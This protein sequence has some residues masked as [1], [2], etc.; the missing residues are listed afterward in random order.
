MGAELR[1]LLLVDALQRQAA[2][3]VAFYPRSRLQ[4]A[5]EDGEI[6]F[7]FENGEACGYLWHGP[8]NPGRD[9]IIY[10]AVIHY[11]LRRRLKG[12][13]LVA[14]LI[15]LAATVGATGVRCRCRSDIEANEFWRTLGFDCIAVGRSGVRRNT[16]VNTWRRPLHVGFWDALTVAPSAKAKDRETYDLLYR[17]DRAALPV[18]SRFAR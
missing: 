2:D 7:A 10:Q 14:R 15:E 9:L 12:A 18:K 6:E 3:Q 5:I 8:P 16:D 4:R 11:D 1:S 13:E 17:T